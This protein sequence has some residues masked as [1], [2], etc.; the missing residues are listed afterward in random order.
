MIGV[1]ETQV[2]GEA[3]AGKEGYIEVDFLRGT[4]AGSPASR[5]LLR[6]IEL[7]RDALPELCQRHGVKVEDFKLLRARFG[8]DRTYGVHYAVTVESSSGKRST[9][10]YVGVPG[11]RLRAR[12]SKS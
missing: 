3:A 8:V 4:A 12:R 10:R 9:N 6:A 1:Y 11:T 5:S 2:F 7:Y